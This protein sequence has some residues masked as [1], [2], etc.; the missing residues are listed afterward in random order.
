MAPRDVPSDSSTSPDA[1]ASGRLAPDGGA[2]ADADPD[3]DSR[4][5]RRAARPGLG[6]ALVGGALGGLVGAAA[7]GVTMIALDT[8]FF[9]STIPSF[10]GLEPGST[11]GWGVHL[12]HGVVLG[13]LFGAVISR[14][15]A[16]EALVPTDP[17][18]LG[19]A[20]FVTRLTAAGVAFGLA[21]WAIL[22]M[23]V[24][25]ALGGSGDR[26]GEL[27]LAASESLIG[28]VAFGLLL[29]VVYAAIVVWR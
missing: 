4:Q 21:V 20:G 23:L 8:A 29:G 26:F 22:P 28:H 5:G 27:S 16:R 13:V 9:R 19:P 7:F 24:L 11:F 12:L 6:R 15:V 1:D 14:D 18:Q 2:V 3:A 17:D 25:P 10:Y